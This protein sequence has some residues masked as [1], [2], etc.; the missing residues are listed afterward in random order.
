[1]ENS[2]VRALVIGLVL[3]GG[4]IGLFL[5]LYFAVFSGSEALVRLLASLLIPPVVMFGLVG[6]YYIL[7]QDESGS[8]NDTTNDDE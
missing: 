7:T 8:S 5:L 4:G 2:L 6:G 1:M 3:A